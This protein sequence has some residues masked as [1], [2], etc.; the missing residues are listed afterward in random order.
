[1]ATGTGKTRVSISLVKVLM[2]ANWVK[3][4]LFLADRTSLV[5]QAHK[6]FNKLLPNVTTSMFTGTSIN[7]DKD[8]RIIFATYQ[9]MIGL[10]DGDTREF[11][12]GRFDLIIVDEAHRSIFGKYPLLFSYFDSLMVGLTAIP[13]CDD[14]KSTYQVFQAVNGEPDYASYEPEHQPS[15]TAISWVSMCSTRQPRAFAGHSTTAFYRR[16]EGRS[17]RLYASADAP[18]NAFD[19]AESLARAVITPDTSNINR[20]TI[21]AI[22]TTSCRTA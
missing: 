19:N 9:T 8:A 13:R 5:R 1:M 11:G 17:R 21:R 10:I 12:I 2:E 4:V 22:P 3:N 16:A 7:R 20:G 14:S 15:T 6:N 18:N